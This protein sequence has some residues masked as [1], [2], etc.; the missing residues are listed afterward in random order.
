MLHQLLLK[1][2]KQYPEKTALVYDNLR[3]TY[4]ELYTKVI[5][6]SNGLSLIGCKAI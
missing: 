5:S 1:T 6:L 3:L 4:Q 2:V